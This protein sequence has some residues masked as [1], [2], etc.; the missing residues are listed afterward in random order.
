M[1]APS[2]KSMSTESRK[3]ILHM[4]TVI[5]SVKTNDVECLL[6]RDHEEF[7]LVACQ[8]VSL[9]DLAASDMSRVELNRC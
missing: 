4:Q 8:E 3:N 5:V 2:K 1:A 9:C 7:G 6:T